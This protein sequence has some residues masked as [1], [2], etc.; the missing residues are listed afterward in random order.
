MKKPG[1]PTGNAAV[2]PVALCDSVN[3]G[4]RFPGYAMPGAARSK[5]E[6]FVPCNFDMVLPLLPCLRLRFAPPNIEPFPPCL[7]AQFVWPT[8]FPKGIGTLS[9]ACC[10]DSGRIFQSLIAN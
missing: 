3:V 8:P 9:D 7:L 4:N 5:H 10:T 1:R 6:S 2:C